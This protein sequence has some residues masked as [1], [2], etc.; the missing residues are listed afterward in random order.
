MK[1]VLCGGG[2][3]RVSPKMGFSRTG[4]CG[5]SGSFGDFGGV[6]LLVQLY[7]QDVPEEFHYQYRENQYASGTGAEDCRQCQGHGDCVL[8]DWGGV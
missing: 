1:L 2:I 5:L 3:S 6:D 7:L 8:L 4:N